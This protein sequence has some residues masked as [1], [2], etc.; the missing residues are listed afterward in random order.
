VV[1]GQLLPSCENEFMLVNEY[2]IGL[3]LL[4]SMD[5][6]KVLKPSMC[7]EEVQMQGLEFENEDFFKLK[8]LVQK[9]WATL[10]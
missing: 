2:D 10:C 5:Y 1:S 6:Y 8:K 7:D 4:L 9:L 3:L